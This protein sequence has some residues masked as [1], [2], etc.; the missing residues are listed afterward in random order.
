MTPAGETLLVLENNT[1]S[2]SIIYFLNIMKMIGT[3]AIDVSMVLY[4]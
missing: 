4:L 2:D 3:D 1:L